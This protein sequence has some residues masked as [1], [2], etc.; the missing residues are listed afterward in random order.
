M[1]QDELDLLVEVRARTKSGE[2]RRIR[3]A[4]GLSQAAIAEAVHAVP[5]TV[6][7]WEQAKRKPTGAAGIAYARLLRRLDRQVKRLQAAA[8]ESAAAES[9]EVAS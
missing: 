6:C 4:A 5:V 7:L 1:T 8:N 3:L 2:A 9:V